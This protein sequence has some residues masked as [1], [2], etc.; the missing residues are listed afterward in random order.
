MCDVLGIKKAQ[1]EGVRNP[2]TSLLEK[3]DVTPGDHIKRM[4]EDYF[5]QV[6]QS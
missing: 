1:L 6:S 5:K 3:L 4:A 2:E